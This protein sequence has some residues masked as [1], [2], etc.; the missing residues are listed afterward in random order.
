M[1]TKYERG[2]GAMDGGGKRR[3]GPQCLSDLQLDQL[4][5]GELDGMT[6]DRARLHLGQCASC[7]SAQQAHVADARAFAQSVNVP[8]VSAAIVARAYPP[9]RL[10]QRWARS[11]AWPTALSVAAAA[12]LVLLAP[13]QSA[14][15]PTERAKGGGLHLT[16]YVK[17]AGVDQAGTLYMGQPLSAGDRVRFQIS[18]ATAGHLAI[19]AIDSGGDVAVFYPAG[20]STV[21]F[22]AG[23][24]IPL[25]NAVEL[26]DADGQE[27]VVALLC[28]QEH[29]ISELVTAARAAATSD[30]APKAIS[31]G[32]CLETRTTLA[33]TRRSSR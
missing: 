21:P 16:T 5:L 19:L 18:S 33:K 22:T 25:G 8:Q 23:Q 1:D 6:A 28:A 24:N 13:L 15:G 27:T 3:Q 7:S 11:L 20:A 10:V 26:D 12:G 30:T 4:A 17:F 14:V 31:V 9:Q 32:G 2:D 29:A